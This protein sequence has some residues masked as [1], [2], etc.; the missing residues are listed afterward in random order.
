M[1]VT[2]NPHHQARDRSTS[3][4]LATPAAI[5]SRRPNLSGVRPSSLPL[6]NTPALVE[7]LVFNSFGGDQIGAL[8]ISPF[9]KPGSTSDTGYNHY[10]LLRSTMKTST[11]FASTWAML[12]TMRARTTF[13]R[14]SGTMRRSSRLGK[15]AVSDAMTITAAGTKSLPDN[16]ASK[17]WS[18]EF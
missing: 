10:S 4:S 12:P 6:V 16:R 18:G 15:S 1:T 5:S 9:I 14:P 7:N 17:L 13:S 11:G 3:H 2:I 8:L